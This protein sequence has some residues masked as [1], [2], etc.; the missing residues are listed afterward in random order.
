MINLNGEVVGINS[1]VV[2]SAQG[3][4]FA[5]GTF[6]AVPVVQSILE[7]GEVI[8][9]WLGISVNDITSNT[10]LELNLIP[11]E[12]VLIEFVWPETPAKFGDLRQGDVIVE[13]QDSEIKNVRH[14]QK[15]LRGG[16]FVGDKVS[17]TILRHGEE[18]TTQITLA[19]MPR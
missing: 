1:I 12:G 13:L 19:E 17:I 8:W 11:R 10:A 2:S 6:T 3:I 9:P 14:L 7:N 4:G 16:F 15:L 18:I 5:V